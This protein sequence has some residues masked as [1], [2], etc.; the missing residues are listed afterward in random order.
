MESWT[1]MGEVGTG[2]TGEVQQ[3]VGCS[4]WR[5][6]HTCEEKEMPTGLP[7]LAWCALFCFVAGRGRDELTRVYCTC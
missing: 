3:L 5:A 2:G 6:M 1:W 4:S 7:M